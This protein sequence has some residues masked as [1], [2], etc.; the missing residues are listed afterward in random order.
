MITPKRVLILSSDV[1]F[2][3]RSAAQAIAAALEEK[4]GAECV[5]EIVNPLDDP[6]APAVLR[7]GQVTYDDIVRE[8]PELQR[9]GYEAV[10]KLSAIGALERAA[11]VLLFRVVYDLIKTRQPDVIVNTFPIYQAPLEAAFVIRKWAC[12]VVTVVTDL[13]AV[14]RAWFHDVADLCVAPTER[15]REMALEAKLASEAVE[16]IG[17]PVHPRVAQERRDPAALRAELGWRP[18]LTTVLAVGSKRVTKLYDALEVLNHAGFPVQIA[19]VAGGDDELYAR[20]QKTE[21]HVPTH[22]YNF[23]GNLP[24]LMKA[25]D[26]L[27]TKAGGLITTEGLACGLPLLIIEYIPGQETGNVEYVVGNGAGAYTEP[28]VPL[29]RTLC[30]WL[31]DDRRLLMGA[32]HKARQLGRPRAAYDIAERVWEYAQQGPARLSR[33]ERLQILLPHVSGL[34]DRFS[35]RWRD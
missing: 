26:L 34:L 13:G 17:I 2:G 30:H 29:L 16:V 27:L 19:A 20:L 25:A 12:P 10:D 24:R 18:D 11:T 28:P 32:A 31:G 21:W 7:R 9:V 33:R 14:S 15:V 3:H 22:V 23:V 5:V 6:R 4:R 8:M 35:V 1:G